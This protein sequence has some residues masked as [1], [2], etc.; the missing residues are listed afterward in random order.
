MGHGQSREASAMEALTG[1]IVGFLLAIW[2]QCLLF[3]A[4]GHDLALSENAVVASVFTVLSL[5]RSYC[6]R[7]LF[8]ALEGHKP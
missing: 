4:M 7:R 1:T 6:L 5:L 8:N 2:V 3:P